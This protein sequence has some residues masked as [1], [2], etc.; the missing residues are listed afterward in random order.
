VNNS[1]LLAGERWLITY[2][3]HNS[4]A[5]EQYLHGTNKHHHTA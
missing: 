5:A 1:Q 4:S 3:A 2:Q